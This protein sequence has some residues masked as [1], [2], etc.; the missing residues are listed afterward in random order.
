MTQ[1]QEPILFPKLR[2]YFAD[3]PYLHC[4]IDQRLFTLE[5]CSGYGYGQARKWSAPRK[6]HAVSPRFSRVVE[7]A[8]DTS[9]DEVLC[10]S[11]DPLSGQPDSRV[12]NFELIFAALLGTPTSRG[13]HTQLPKRTPRRP[14]A[15]PRASANR[16]L[17]LTVKKKRELFPG[18]PP[19]SRGSFVLPHTQ[20][21]LKSSSWFRN[22][23]L[24]PFRSRAH[25]QRRAHP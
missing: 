10:R 6:G 1:P 4:S 21:F 25:W 20:L 9:K 14:M 24:I 16:C 18:P 22:F 19:T 5:T 2:I 7:G 23:D 17:C 3:F 13:A 8:P 11:S 12:V 15:T